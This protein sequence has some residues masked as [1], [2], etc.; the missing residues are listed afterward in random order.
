MGCVY[1]NAELER[2]EKLI[3]TN[4]QEF[5]KLLL[6]QETAISQLDRKFG[7]AIQKEMT[8]YLRYLDEKG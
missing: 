3:K 8:S 4:K 7:G 5:L 1:D 6:R 2:L